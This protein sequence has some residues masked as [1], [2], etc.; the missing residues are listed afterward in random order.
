MNETLSWYCY[1]P[2][3]GPDHSDFVPYLEDF[4]ELIPLTS[5]LFSQEY[6]RREPSIYTLPLTLVST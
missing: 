6:L 3:A 4:S 2:E 5:N 1:E